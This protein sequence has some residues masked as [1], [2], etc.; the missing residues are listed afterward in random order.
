[1]SQK[2]FAVFVSD[3]STTS[4][5]EESVIS[6]INVATPDTSNVSGSTNIV[7]HVKDIIST[8]ISTTDAPGDVI[9]PGGPEYDDQEDQDVTSQSEATTLTPLITSTTNVAITT[10]SRAAQAT[11]MVVKSEV[12][13]INIESERVQNVEKPFGSIGVEVLETSDNDEGAVQTPV[14]TSTPSSTTKNV[15]ASVT[16]TTR[17]TQLETI[18]PGI[19]VLSE[20]GLPSPHEADS[21][22]VPPDAQDDQSST[23]SPSVSGSESVLASTP[24]S[25]NEGP[26]PTSESVIS[27][28]TTPSS[29]PDSQLIVVTNSPGLLISGDADEKGSQLPITTI[30]QVLDRESNQPQQTVTT[31]ITTPPVT[32]T[33]TAAVA[34]TTAKTDT[35]PETV[36]N[37]ISGLDLFESNSQTTSTTTT[38]IV[39]GLQSTSPTTTSATPTTTTLISSTSSDETENPNLG[40]ESDYGQVIQDNDV[41][42]SIEVQTLVNGAAL[43]TTSTETPTLNDRT[44]PDVIPTTTMSGRP[45]DVVF[46]TEVETLVNEAVIATTS[47]EPPAKI[48]LTESNEKR[49]FDVFSSTERETLVNEAAITT[50]STEAPAVNDRTETNVIH[51]TISG[52]PF[53]VVWSTEWETL[54]NEAVITTTSTEA[55]AVNDRT[56]PN[57]NLTTTMPERPIDLVEE[58]TTGSVLILIGSDRPSPVPNDV[59]TTKSTTLE[60]KD[61]RGGDQ[62]INPETR[63]ATDATTI[64]SANPIESSTTKILPNPEPAYAVVQ[65]EVPELGITT[66]SPASYEDSSASS[67]DQ[68]IPVI[69]AAGTADNRDQTVDQSPTAAATSEKTSELVT[70]LSHAPEMTTE[71]LVTTTTGVTTSPAPATTTTTTSTTSSRIQPE[72][73]LVKEIESTTLV[74]AGTDPLPQTTPESGQSSQTTTTVA[75]SSDDTTTPGTKLI[76]IIDAELTSSLSSVDPEAIGSTTISTTTTTVTSLPL[77]T[78]AVSREEPVIIATEVPVTTTSTTTT[79]TTTTVPDTTTAESTVPEATTT[80]STTGVRDTTSASDI[81]DTGS[82][83]P[84]LTTTAALPTTLKNKAS[85]GELI[86]D[87]TSTS[88]SPD[89]FDDRLKTEISRQVTTKTSADFSFT[90][91]TTTTTT[92]EES[93]TPNVAF[94]TANVDTATTTVNPDEGKQRNEDKGSL[95]DEAFEEILKPCADA[96][97]VCNETRPEVECLNTFDKC[98]IQVLSDKEKTEGVVPDELVDRIE[99]GTTDEKLPSSLLQCILDNHDCIDYQKSNCMA[100]YNACS[101][102]ALEDFRNRQLRLLN[103]TDEEPAV[104][105][106]R[107]SDETEVEELNKYLSGNF[108][109]CVQSYTTCTAQ[110][111]IALEINDCVKRF[112]SCSLQLLKNSNIEEKPVKGIVV[113]PVNDVEGEDNKKLSKSLFSCIQE[114]IMCLMRKENW[115]MMTYNNCTLIV[116]DKDA[117]LKKEDQD[118]QND[119]Q[120]ETAFAGPAREGELEL[121]PES[122]SESSMEGTLTM[123]NEQSSVEPSDNNDNVNAQNDSQNETAFTGPAREGELELEPESSSKSST[124]GTLTTVNEPSSVEPSENSDNL[125][126]QSTT[127]GKIL[128]QKKLTF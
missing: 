41:V 103:G 50:T 19:N 49:P 29:K 100:D 70:T 116:L 113:E 32:T 90:T 109:S 94:T 35:L 82:D 44:R 76:P 66:L 10:T 11:T 55:P 95:T 64:N 12:D 48:D 54:V 27:Q 9:G 98:S 17:T 78:P 121:E 39:L 26:G 99:E 60:S 77:T 106:S 124:E 62:V 31:T 115:C 80:V 36:T 128:K 73:I 16:T 15:T 86:I 110:A 57:M 83:F 2:S 119:S 125:N 114:Y 123:V 5:T 43:T 58:T 71:I 25:R 75:A 7:N 104:P 81:P 107:A 21:T 47:T 24:E 30:P 120:N 96:Y 52:R 56:G 63:T 65:T 88:E 79:T 38:E 18:T 108:T 92:T 1:M 4:T 117:K 20:S 74:N 6:I 3:L 8:F 102:K 37:K 23:Q 45:F 34:P 53:E 61:Q 97:F 42:S 14:V 105:A 112:H 13:Q 122:T 40:R 22:H 84:V 51:S 126:A 85:D 72:S 67:V 33:A 87:D 101:L 111:T 127:A 118:A 89:S 91:S 93:T 46:S 28:D 69:T 68:Q 59:V